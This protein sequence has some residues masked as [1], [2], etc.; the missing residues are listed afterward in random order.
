MD[1]I[2]YKK[3]FNNISNTR[4][5][6]IFSYKLNAKIDRRS[7]KRYCA[8]EAKIRGAFV[9][10]PQLRSIPRNIKYDIIDQKLKFWAAM[11]LEQG[12]FLSS[13]ILQNKAPE[14]Y[15]RFA[16]TID[17]DE[18]DSPVEFKASK[19]WFDKFLKR[20]VISLKQFSGEGFETKNQDFNEFFF[21]SKEK[22]EFYG[23]DNVFNF[24]ETGLFYK[25]SPSN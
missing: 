25:L 15:K 10:N 14:I 12:G 1:K 8:N 7:V 9:S 20:H 24:D 21:L 16:P 13:M 11:V 17:D 5:A 3:Q 2:D 6:E 23:E 22:M 19:G 18:Q 4:I